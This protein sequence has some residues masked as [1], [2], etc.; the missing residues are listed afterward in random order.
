MQVVGGGVVQHAGTDDVEGQV[1]VAQRC[2]VPEV[3][4]LEPEPLEIRLDIV[5]PAMHPWPGSASGAPRRER[6]G[7]DARR[8][9]LPR[10]DAANVAHSD[11]RLA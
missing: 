3:G 10:L 2:E 9:P 4:H 5:A 7:V 6:V 11:P 8:G 1:G